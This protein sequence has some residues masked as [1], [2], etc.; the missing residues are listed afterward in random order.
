MSLKGQK[1]TADFM[2]WNEFSTLLLKL[3]KDKEF[4][5]CLL[6]AIGSSLGLRIADILNFKW[7]DFLINRT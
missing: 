1:T 4:K 2:E 6:I 5:F 3:Q 7:Q